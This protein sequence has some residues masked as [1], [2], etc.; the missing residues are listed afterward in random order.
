MNPG[1]QNNH[2][3]SYENHQSS[4]DHQIDRTL[5]LIG[6]VHPRPGIEKRIAARLAHTQCSSSVRFLGMPRLVIASA[7]GLCASVAIVAGSVN[8]S[9]RLLP[10]APGLQ[11]HRSASSGLSTASA[12]QVA[13]KPVTPPANG[14]ARSMRKL[15]TGRTAVAPDTQRPS[16]VAVPK[17]PL[18]QQNPK[19]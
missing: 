16:G 4:V 6:S 3:N 5:H 14:R 8:H 18:P 2:E 12:T 13:P 1:Y 9:R 10:I 19:E 11:V 15:G 17:N 7:A